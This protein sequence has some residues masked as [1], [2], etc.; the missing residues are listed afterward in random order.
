MTRRADVVIIGSGPAGLGAA[1]VTAQAGLD[2]VVIDEYPQ[3]GGRLLGQL[4]EEPGARPPTWWKGAEVASQM[5]AD[6]RAAG[7]DLLCGTD[8][9]GIFPTEGGSG[10]RVCLSRAHVGTVVSDFVVI[11]AGA[12]ERGLPLPGWELPGV[13]TVGGAQVMANVH[14]VRPGRRA[15]VVGTDVLAFTIARELALAGVDVVGIVQPGPLASLDRR[16]APRK[17]AAALLGLAHLAPTAWIRAVGPW[18]R[19]GPFPDLAARLYP[20]R[21]VTVW[22][23]PVQL[24]RA[25]IGIEGRDEVE[26][27]I[28]ADIDVHGKVVPGTEAPVAVDC[29]ALSGGLY[30]MVELAASLGCETAYVEQLGGHVPLHGEDFATTAPGV[31]VAG[32]ITGIEGATIAAAQ[33]R[34]AGTALALQAGRLEGGRAALEEALAHVQEARSGTPFAFLPDIVSGRERMQLLWEQRRG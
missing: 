21:G 10:W 23:I 8:A 5:I 4:H 15:V 31:Y 24:R 7:A 32:S 20:K 22:N 3:P 27:V 26:G 2:T 14:R 28:L 1:I 6:A 13:M 30:P 16:P 33:G 9:W 11:A 12:G 25:C 34:A 17:D 19:R 29:V 18:L